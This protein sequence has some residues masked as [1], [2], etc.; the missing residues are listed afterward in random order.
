[1]TTLRTAGAV[2]R[3]I[4]EDVGRSARFLVPLLLFAAVL[5]VLFGGDPGPLPLPWAASALMLYPVGA[6]LTHC[7]A[8]TEDDVQ[9]TV[10]VSAAG[11]PAPVT[12]GVLMAGSA[13]VA[14]LSLLALVWGTVASFSSATV[15][16]LFDGLCAHLACGLTGVAVGLVFARPLI[17]HLGW[18]VLGGVTFVVV[19]GTQ[20]WL[21]PV[22]AAAAALGSDR[23]GIG[24]FGDLVLAAVLAIATTA[25]VVRAERGWPA[26]WAERVAALRRRLPGRPGD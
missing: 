25:L 4:G 26:E 24:P 8:E 13:G 5:A 2:A 17:G 11:G 14:V 22:G 3:L 23:G 19:T 21:P 1:V 9:R 15:G 10:T 12:I 20:S 7:L 18:A 16:N 6:W